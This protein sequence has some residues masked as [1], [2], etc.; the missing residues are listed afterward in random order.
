MSSG[1]TNYWEMASAVALGVAMISMSCTSFA[2]VY[3]MEDTVE[4]KRKEYEAFP[5]D[6]EV[7]AREK[8]V[9]SEEARV[10]GRDVLERVAEARQV[11]PRRVALPHDPRVPHR[12][13]L[14]Q[15]LLCHVFRDVLRER[16]PTW[17]CPSG[18][19]PSGCS[20]RDA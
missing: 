10:Q 16:S 6:E 20:P 3:Y 4:N 12:G 5:V 18:G 7:E 15:P 13:Q 1:E 9:Q 19:S 17:C 14:W 2:A 11:P 8:K